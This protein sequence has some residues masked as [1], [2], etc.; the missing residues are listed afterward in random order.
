MDIQHHP[1]LLDR[2]A[3]QY[4]L[5]S[6]RAGAR[7]RLEAMAREQPPVRAALLIWQ[8]RLASLA[9][10]QPAQRPAPEVWTRIDNLVAADVVRQSM[11]AGATRQAPARGGWLGSLGL[12]RG[13]AAS[14][15]AAA[16]LALV[17]TAQVR[18]RL[19][20]EVATLQTRLATTPQI[21]Y[22]AV[23]VHAQPGTTE[24]TASMLVTFDAQNGQLV[25]QR[26]G[27]YQ[28]TPDKS[29]QL[30]ALPP[31]GAPRSLGVLGRD[32]VLRIPAGPGE[33]RE[34]P[35]LAISLEPRGGV[36]G[37]GGPTGPVLFKGAL[38]QKT[39]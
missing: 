13:L 36:P 37:A 20:Q 7:R 30:W 12:W 2:L 33:V 17:N 3:S 9:E 19:G 14:G 29:L 11:Q 6:L 4:A 1:E 16:V 22:V 8:A 26:V 34:V 18:E 5:G 38:I 35:A 23:L 28:E 32:R 15:V 31:S 21:Q 27:N 39:S 24:D 25:L 10:L